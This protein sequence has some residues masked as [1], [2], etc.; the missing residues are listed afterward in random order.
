MNSF[1]PIQLQNFEGILI[2]VSISCRLETIFAWHGRAFPAYLMLIYTVYSTVAVCIVVFG[3][4]NY[5]SSRILQ[6]L[7]TPLQNVG[8]YLLLLPF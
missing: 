5:K 6:G 7:T 2:F 8:S 1:V 4:K 3:V